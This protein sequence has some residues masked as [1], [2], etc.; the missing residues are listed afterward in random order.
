[1]QHTGRLRQDRIR[2]EARSWEGARSQRL[3]R[4]RTH[5][6]MQNTKVMYC[7]RLTGRPQHPLE[8]RLLRKER[9]GQRLHGGQARAR[10][11]HEQAA[12]Q[13]PQLHIDLHLQGPGTQRAHSETSETRA[14]ILSTVL[15]QPCD[16]A[17]RIRQPQSPAGTPLFS[18]QS[19]LRYQAAVQRARRSGMAT[20]PREL[21]VQR[22]RCLRP[23]PQRHLPGPRRRCH[24]S[25]LRRSCTIRDAACSRPA[26]ACACRCCALWFVGSARR[27][28]PQPVG[29][30]PE[31]LRRRVAREE[32]P[33]QRHL[34]EDAARRP[35]VRRRGAP[36]PSGR[37]CGQ[38]TASTRQSQVEAAPGRLRW[39]KSC[40]PPHV[41]RHRP[42]V[43]GNY[44]SAIG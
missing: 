28:R 24:D 23:G 16:Q 10:V 36:P 6:R 27:T 15:C 3:H 37:L 38:A 13:V 35:H 30:L 19:S 11:L 22:R 1:M 17:S 21:Q 18:S 43:V 39:C 2:L 12:H 31:Q 26:G 29:D 42:R 25:A 33:P 40:G 7:S 20:H 14:W 9:V 8:V 44:G 4:C 34:R 5:Q 41:D 32:R